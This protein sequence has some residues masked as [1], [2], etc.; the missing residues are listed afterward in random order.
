MLSASSFPL[1]S[2]P[3]SVSR[4]SCSSFVTA[5]KRRYGLATCKVLHAV[6]Y[7]GPFLPRTGLPALKGEPTTAHSS[8]TRKMVCLI[9][10]EANCRPVKAG[11]GGCSF[12][13]VSDAGQTKLRR[14]TPALHYCRYI[15]V[16][17][18]HLHSVRAYPNGDLTPGTI[19]GCYGDVDIAFDGFPRNES[20][21][22]CNYRHCS[23]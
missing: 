19:R 13:N 16:R 21:G 1:I 17:G 4:I 23:I 2:C 9:S 18:L 7:A 12:P 3:A 15:S 22:V 20:V 8:F 10:N 11:V 5:F 6:L 14:L